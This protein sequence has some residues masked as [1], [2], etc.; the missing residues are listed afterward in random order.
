MLLS[1]GL[2]PSF[3]SPSPPSPFTL[4]RHGG[5]CWVGFLRADSKSGARIYLSVLRVGG[6]G[7]GG[8]GENWLPSLTSKWE[9]RLSFPRNNHQI[10]V[11]RGGLLISDSPGASPPTTAVMVQHTE[12]SHLF[13]EH[14]LL[15]RLVIGPQPLELGSMS[16]L[17]FVASNT[18]LSCSKYLTHI[19]TSSSGPIIPWKS[20]KGIIS[21]GLTN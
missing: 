11:I 21:Q 17:C 20:L 13:R 16:Y 12:V 5:G 14:P 19:L 7:N 1:S 18:E 6:S 9:K 4:N 8:G 2:G 3:P 10:L 15:H